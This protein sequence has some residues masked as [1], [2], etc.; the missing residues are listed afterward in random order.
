M[1]PWT[2]APS[3]YR[4]LSAGVRFCLLLFCGWSRLVDGLSN[5][6]VSPDHAEKPAPVAW[7]RWLQPPRMAAATAPCD[8]VTPRPQGRPNLVLA[9]QSFLI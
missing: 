5:V 8:V 6:D 4:L 2:D 9:K 7:V 3:L 1:I